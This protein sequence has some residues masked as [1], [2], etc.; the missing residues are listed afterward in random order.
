MKSIDYSYRPESYFGPML[1]DTRTINRING[2]VR[3]SLVRE[4]AGDDLSGIPE[5][6]TGE[7]L[8]EVG[9]RAWGGIHPMFMG[10]EFLPGFRSGEIEIARVSIKSTTYDV[11]SIRAKMGANRIR[12]RFYD[13]Y[14]GETT[15][16]KTSRTSIRPLTLGKLL[17]FMFRAHHFFKMLERNYPAD[18]EGQLSFFRGESNFYPQF[19]D[20]LV[21]KTTEHFYKEHGSNDWLMDRLK[22]AF[23]N[24]TEEEIIASAGG[25]LG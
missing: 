15:T 17:D 22:A 6:I 23:P 5:E 9:I 8:D 24:L 19:H 3:R 2:S 11:N 7:V 21:E 12:Y 1:S 4:S 14:D 16:G 10:G 18:L 20:A 25:L 13:E